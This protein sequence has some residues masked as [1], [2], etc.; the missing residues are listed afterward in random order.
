MTYSFNFAIP[1]E[2][3]DRVIS[4]ESSTGFVIAELIVQSD[5]EFCRNVRSLTL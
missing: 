3:Y 2:N 5:H 1:T 4:F